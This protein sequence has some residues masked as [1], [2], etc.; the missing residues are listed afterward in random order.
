MQQVQERLG[1]LSKEIRAMKSQP[2][3]DQAELVQS[4][5]ISHLMK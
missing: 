2:S 5:C 3:Y 1:Q 4:K